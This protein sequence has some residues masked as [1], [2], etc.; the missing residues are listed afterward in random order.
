[1]TILACLRCGDEFPVD[2]FQLVPP[3]TGE[4]PA[5]ESW[6]RCPGCGTDQP[7]GAYQDLGD[8]LDSVDDEDDW[9]ED[10]WLEDNWLDD[11]DDD[12]W[13]DDSYDPLFEVFEDEEEEA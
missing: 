4:I 7:R 8:D 3:R 13:L 6:L 10:D 1:M 11:D 5:G 2:C 9:L 12:D